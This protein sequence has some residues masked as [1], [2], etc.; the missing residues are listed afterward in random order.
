MGRPPKITRAVIAKASTLRA[1]GY[2]VVEIADRL[3]V[4]KSQLAAALSATGGAAPT[5]GVPAAPKSK[6]PPEPES[7]PAI[8]TQ[9]TEKDRQVDQLLVNSRSWK[10]VQ[11]ALAR[12]LAPHPEAARDVAREL[13]KVLL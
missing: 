13:R 6:A 11:A 10:R 12:A 4:G 7:G 3:G 2:G 1:E 5:V 8:E 9:A